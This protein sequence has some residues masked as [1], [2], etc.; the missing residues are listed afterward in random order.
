MIFLPDCSAK[1][2]GGTYCDAK[3]PSFRFLRLL[4]KKTKAISAITK[5]PATATPT[6]VLVLPE[7]VLDPPELELLV[8]SG[9]LLDV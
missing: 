6:A 7:D 5:T 4:T 3:A 1:L 2:V 8:E 9:S